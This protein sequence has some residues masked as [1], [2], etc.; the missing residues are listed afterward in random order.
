MLEYCL[1]IPVVSCGRHLE[2]N[3][4]DGRRRYNQNVDIHPRSNWEVLH[5]QQQV[6][7]PE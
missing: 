1:E 5:D 6:A 7:E 3:H 4:K 2:D